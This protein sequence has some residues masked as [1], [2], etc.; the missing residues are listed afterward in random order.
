[1]YDLCWVCQKNNSAVYHSSN[2]TDENK[3][4]RLKKQEE[5]LLQVSRERSLYQEL[6][7]DAKLTVKDMGWKLGQNDPCSKDITMHYSFDYAQQIHY[8]SDPM[9]PG[10][11]YFLVPRKCG[12]FGVCCEAI[13]QQVNYLIDEAVVTGKGSNAVISFVHHF[14]DNWSLGEKSVHI[15]CDNCSGQNKNNFMVWYLM[16]RVMTGLHHNVELHF[17]LAGHTKFAPDWCFGLIKQKYRRTLTSSLDD[18]A[19]VVEDSSQVGGF[20]LLIVN[21]SH[22]YK[23]RKQCLLKV[24]VSKKRLLQQMLCQ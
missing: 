3:T 11:M 4:A 5:H 7:K 21:L 17:L 14:F 8:P 9:Q 19:K 20:L 18:F 15:N 22:N 24:T 2:T 13:P 6:V 16:W 1:M 12:L 23:I 10:P